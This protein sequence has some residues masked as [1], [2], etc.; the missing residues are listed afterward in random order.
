MANA[1]ADVPRSNKSDIYDYCITYNITCTKSSNNITAD[2]LNTA[3]E[4][5]DIAY[6]EADT[7]YSGIINSENNL[8]ATTDVFF[9]HI[10]INDE[11]LQPNG[12]YLNRNDE[13][14]QP[15]G[16]YLEPND[17]HLQPNGE[18]MQCI[19]NS[20]H[21]APETQRP[22][23]PLPFD[24]QRPALPLAEQTL[25]YNETY[26]DTYNFQPTDTI[27]AGNENTSTE[28]AT[29]LEPVAPDNERFVARHELESSGSEV[30][31]S[32]GESYGRPF[33]V[34]SDY[35]LFN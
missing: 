12:E 15:N 7:F 28:S 24:T 33:D 16:E 20:L 9:E 19:A 31:T 4:E 6:Q 32:L 35:K 27:R 30:D 5:L 23:L 21:S 10:S 25:Q 14:L 17:E 8:P 18:Y 1:D 22:V 29:Y 2:D 26:G 34:G 13:Y 11:R 3:Y